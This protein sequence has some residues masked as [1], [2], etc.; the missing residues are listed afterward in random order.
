MSALGFLVAPDYLPAHFGTWYMLNAYLQKATGIDIHL[1]MPTSASEEERLINAGKADMIY[2]N[3]FDAARLVR[4]RGYVA[5]AR[6]VDNYDEVVVVVA[7]DSPFHKIEDLP[8]GVRVA[9]PPDKNVRNIG[10]RLLE[11]ADLNESNIQIEETDA[12]SKVTAGVLKGRVQ[13]GFFL[14]T[15]YHQLSE[16]SRENMRVL[17][18]SRIHDIYHVILLHPD[19]IHLKQTLTDAILAINTTQAGRKILSNLGMEKGFTVLTH[20]DVEFMID[21]TETLVN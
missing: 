18:E 9:F 8:H 5:L 13:V 14:S 1:H 19:H 15:A 2:A 16:L 11:V 3:P 6:P 17:L 4:E 20:G 10:L 12:F 7:A 21:L